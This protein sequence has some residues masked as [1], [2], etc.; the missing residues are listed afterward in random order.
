MKNLIKLNVIFLVFF[1]IFSSHSIAAD[2]ILPIPKPT[3]DKETK[4]KSA[5]KKL[6]YPQKKTN[7][8]KKKKLMLRKVK[9]FLK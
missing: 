3:P 1:I 4:A 5:E 6:I 7:I 8:K 2:Q 9:R